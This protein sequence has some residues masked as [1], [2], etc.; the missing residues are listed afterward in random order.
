LR[1]EGSIVSGFQGPGF[2]GSRVQGSK[3]IFLGFRV[4]D[5]RVEG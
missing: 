5:S 4:Q 2:K 3:V 1:V